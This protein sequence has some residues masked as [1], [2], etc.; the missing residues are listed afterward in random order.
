MNDFS[1]TRLARL[2]EFL[3][4]L[5][6]LELGLAVQQ[7]VN[8]PAFA[9]APVRSHRV[10]S[11]GCCCG[12]SSRR[13]WRKPHTEEYYDAETGDIIDFPPMPGALERKLLRIC[14]RSKRRRKELD[15]L[16]KARIAARG[17]ATQSLDSAED[18]AALTL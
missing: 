11:P 17:S 4:H 14:R 10:R 6:L 7:E 18:A 12:A 2:I 8:H 13:G 5:A 16:L 9:T 1:V 15:K 3:N